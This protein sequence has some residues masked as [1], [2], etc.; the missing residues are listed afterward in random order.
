MA[1]GD[2]A[3]LY[4]RDFEGND[5]SAEEGHD[6]AD[7]ANE[8]RAGFASGPEHRFGPLQG[9]NGGGERFGEDVDRQAAGG[10][11]VEF[12]IVPGLL[13]LAGVDALLFREAQRG[14]FAGGDGRTFYDFGAIGGAVGNLR[15]LDYQAAR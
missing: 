5:L 1:S 7:G 8:A 10:G 14:L 11:L 13:Y 6:P 12:V 2:V 4:S 9:E 3:G 15:G